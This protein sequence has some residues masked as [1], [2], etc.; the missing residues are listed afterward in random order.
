MK[1]RRK[2][3]TYLGFTPKQLEMIACSHDEYCGLKRIL[4]K[5]R[6]SKGDELTCQ[7]AK[8]FNKYG[9]ALNQLGIGATSQIKQNIDK[10]Y[11]ED[12]EVY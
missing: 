8:L 5:E 7:T 11:H 12:M 9:E 4:E 10:L 3:K 1:L 2:T 6:C